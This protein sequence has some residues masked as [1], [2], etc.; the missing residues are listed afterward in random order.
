ME[1][2]LDKYKYHIC[3]KAD[4]SPYKIVATSTYAGKTVRGVSKCDPKDTF[5][6]EAGKELAAARCNEKVARKRADRAMKKVLE[7]KE[8]YGRE[9]AWYN[10]MVDY[11]NDS[12]NALEAAQKRVAE[13]ETNM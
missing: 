8:S 10:R 12:N 7:A 13:L 5:S 1:Y 11:Y 2:S 9:I 6:M 3:T 4:G